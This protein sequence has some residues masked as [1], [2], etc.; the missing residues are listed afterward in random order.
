MTQEDQLLLMIPEEHRAA[1]KE[2]AYKMAHGCAMNH[3]EAL[4]L[5]IDTYRRY[6]TWQT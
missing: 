3:L 1:V 6:R 4:E 2:A 5:L